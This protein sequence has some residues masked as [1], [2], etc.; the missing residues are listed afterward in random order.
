LGVAEWIPRSR[1]TVGVP[2]VYP[3]GHEATDELH[4]Q[5][6][7]DVEDLQPIHV[8]IYAPGEQL[9]TQLFICDV[10]VRWRA[11]CGDEYV[12]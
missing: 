11:V 10:R 2:Q 4:L 5:D 8:F 9:F 3:L 6:A 12:A 7:L 1:R